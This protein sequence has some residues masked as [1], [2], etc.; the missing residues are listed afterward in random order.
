MTDEKTNDGAERDQEEPTPVCPG[1]L[2]PLPPAANVCPKCLKPISPF[3]TIDPVQRIW[4]M[5]DMYNRATKAAPSKLVLM[6]ATF[7]A[8]PLLAPVLIVGPA[9]LL[10]GGFEGVEGGL[11]AAVGIIIVSLY[12]YWLAK[13]WRNYFHAR[14]AKAADD[15]A[16]D[17]GREG[18]GAKDG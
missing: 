6:G 9:E 5:G 13:V 15:D 16:E 12:T 10:F 7:I 1:C 14:T 18:E 4:A 2:A 11:A 17:L 8:L 3:A